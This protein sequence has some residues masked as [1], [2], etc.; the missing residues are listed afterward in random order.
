M[1]SGKTVYQIPHLPLQY[2][3]HEVKAIVVPLLGGFL[4]IVGDGGDDMRDQAVDGVG[5]AVVLVL[6]HGCIFARTW[7][8]FLQDVDYAVRSS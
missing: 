6:R 1:V 2:G 7:D 8:S 3:P 4:V 5:D